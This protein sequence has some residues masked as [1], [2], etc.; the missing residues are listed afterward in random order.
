M[1]TGLVIAISMFVFIM[2][3]LYGVYTSATVRDQHVKL[4]L[5]HGLDLEKCAYVNGW[6]E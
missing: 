3:A 2:G 1:N 4:C 5:A 6:I